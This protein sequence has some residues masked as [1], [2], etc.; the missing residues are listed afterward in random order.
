MAGDPYVTSLHIIPPP[1]SPVTPVA[2]VLLTPLA[3]DC[4]QVLVPTPGPWTEAEEQI[5]WLL[6][7][8][9]VLHCA[10]A[11]DVDMKKLE[12]LA[13]AR[14]EVKFVNISYRGLTTR[15]FV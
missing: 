14:V 5:M 10:S 12:G 11:Y 8:A 13:K 6:V 3:Y 9:G 4:L 1:P 15:M 2:L 7:L